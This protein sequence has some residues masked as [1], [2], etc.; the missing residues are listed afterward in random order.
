MLAGLALVLGAVGVYGVISHSVLRRSRE[1]GIRLALGQQ[2]ALIMR[3]VAGHAL[4]LVAFG[5]TVG[6]ALALG[7]SRLLAALLYGVEPTDPIAMAGA[8]LVLLLV[9]MLAA[10][11]PAR[12]ASLTDPAVVLRQP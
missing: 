1:F 11:V 7:V 9:G 2:P 4:A 5:A 6:L 3:Q 12:R 10:L 8:L